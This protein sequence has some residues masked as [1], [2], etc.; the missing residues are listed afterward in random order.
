MNLSYS[1]STT[2]AAEDI[3]SEGE[4]LFSTQ[5]GKIIPILCAGLIA[6]L[7]RGRKP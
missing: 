4:T 7:R 3:V 2:W 6:A 1:D 5:S